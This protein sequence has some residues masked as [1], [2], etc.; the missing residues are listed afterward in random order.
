M[1]AYVLISHLSGFEGLTAAR[2]AD[3][4]FDM[5]AKREKV[6]IPVQQE[7]KKNVNKSRPSEG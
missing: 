3:I 4:V 1:Y 7:T 5:E 2:I 6:R